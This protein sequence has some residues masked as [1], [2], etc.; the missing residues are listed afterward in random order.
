MD[1][2]K[3]QLLQVEAL[4]EV[5]RICKKYLI[6][7]Y[8]TSGTLIGAVRHKGFIP[9]DDD[10]DIAMLRSDYDKF[11]SCSQGELGDKYFLQNYQTDIDYYPALT[12]VCI[13]GT[14]LNDKHI[15]HLKCN[16]A[17]YL[18]I[19]PLDNVP[20]EER[21]QKKQARKI[22]VISK[23]MFYKSGI[24]FLNGPLFVKLVAK[25]VLQV[26]LLPVS[27]KFLHQRRENAMLEYSKQNT[28][29]VCSTA[30][31]YGY[32]VQVMPLSIYGEPVLL[33]FE[34]GMYYAPQE[35]DTHLKKIYG[36]YMV[37]PPEDKRRPTQEVY[38]V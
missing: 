25:K 27:L 36:D 23:L 15:R 35:W 32:K 21:M 14:Y 2:R 9:W 20:A 13:M 38:E 11:L 17:L 5:D 10:I 1:L 19:F 22:H 30:S 18:D 16:K 3:V 8:M 7:Y 29:N 28:I 12:R 26:L 24:V 6:K 4:K 37:L 33:D 31:K 34:G